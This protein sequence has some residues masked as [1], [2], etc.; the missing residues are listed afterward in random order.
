MSPWIKAAYPQ[1]S[2]ALQS[3][4][5]KSTQKNALQWLPAWVHF[6]DT[7]NIIRKLVV[8]WLPASVVHAADSEMSQEDFLNLCT[9]LALT[10]DIGK[11]TPVFQSGISEQFPE[12][13]TRIEQ[14]GLLLYG[15]NSLL[16][17]SNSPHALA[18]EAI[19][20]DFDCPQ[21]VAVVVGAHHGKPQEIKY[22][23]ENQTRYYEENYYGCKGKDSEQGKLWEAVRQ[24]WLQFSLETSGYTSVEGLPQLNMGAQMLLTGLLIMADWIASNTNYFPLI[25][26]DDN[27]ADSSVEYRVQKAWETLHLPDL[28]TP[29]CFFMDDAQFQSRFGFLPNEVQKT[30]IKAAEDA[31]QPGILILE[32]QMGVGKTEA[33]LAAA[34]V[35]TAKTG[36]AGLFFGLPTQATANGIFPRLE[37]WAMEQSEDTLHSIRLAHG[38]AELNEQYQALFHGASQ[39]AEDMNPS[40]LVAHQ[41]FEGRKQALLSDFVIGTV[42]QLLMAALKQKHVMLRH[43]GLAGKIVIVDECHAFDAYMNTYLDR[44]LMW[45]GGYGVPVILLSA[46][47]PE[48]RRLEFISAYLGR[49]KLKDDELPVSRAYPIL[50]WTD[51]EDIKQQAISVDTPSKTVSV[52]CIS[53][54][55]IADCLKQALSEGGCA[56]VIVNTVSRAQNLADNLK[57][58]LPD[59]EI[60]VFHSHFLM[61]D[62]AQKEHVLLQRLGKKSTPD[63]RDNLIVV[64]TQVLEQ[65]LDIDFDVLITDLCPMD[66]L[67]QRLGRLHRHT[68]KRPANVTQPCCAVL[69]ANTETLEEGSRFVY[70]DWLLLQTKRLLPNSITLPQDIPML[71]Q[72]TYQEPQD[73]SELNETAR[74]AWSDYCRHIDSQ[75]EK[76]KVYSIPKP[77]LSKRYAN[78]NVIS[79]LLSTDL[80]DNEERAQATVR[81]GDASISVLVMMLRKDGQISFLPWQNGGVVVP[82]NHVPSEEECRQ[83]AR[84]RM[85]LPRVFCVGKNLD[86]TIE[87]LER[88]NSQMIPEWQES[89]W[90][91]GELILLLNEACSAE[92]CGFHITYTQEEGLRYGKEEEHGEPRM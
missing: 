58:L 28:W 54:E 8:T 18:G 52:K 27:G 29:S 91:K 78:L 86:R 3:L 63:T 9:F 25:D 37:Q 10:H 38:M 34:E 59:T 72:D 44:A 24:E 87:E 83:I 73:T 39:L 35:L 85:N 12:L 15:M 84:Q 2:P 36:S 41:W 31:V 81:D 20:L 16:S 89:F 5:A 77:S 4:A 30:M 46:T 7:A 56:G 79:D 53:D 43:L 74:Q 62:R 61:P 55:A 1:F 23:V 40:G 17:A 76:A 71:V 66:L 68:R 57:K 42:D 92:L 14:S 50:T 47:L 6:A 88:M 22:D 60:L 67:L 32:A 65:S 11:L 21:S 51:G 90:I 33:A 70:G 19:L 82:A 64:G 80:P 48:K 49:K 45:L 13:R 26:I 75:K 69:G